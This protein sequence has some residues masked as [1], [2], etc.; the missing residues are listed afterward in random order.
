MLTFGEMMVDLDRLRE[1]V[2]TRFF[3]DWCLARG[4]IHVFCACLPWLEVSTFK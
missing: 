4:E 3:G 2:R 1:I